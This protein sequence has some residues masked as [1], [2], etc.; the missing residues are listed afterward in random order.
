MIGKCKAIA[1]GSTAL[2]YIFRE[3]KLGCRLAFHNLCSRESKAIHEEMK[4]VSDYN[5]RCRNKFLRIEIGIAPQDEKKLSVSELAQIAHLFAKKMGLDNHQWVA[6]THK[7]TDNRHIHIIANRI[8]LY[9]EVYDTTFVSN[10]AARITEEISREKGLTIAKEVKTE[11]KHQK[12]KANPTREETKK[13]LQKICYIL[14]DKYKCTGI[15]GH[16]MFLYELNKNGITIERVKNK[17]GKVYGLKFS[18]GEHTFKASEIGREF[19]Y[20]S[21]QKNFEAFN[22]EE[23]NKPHQVTQE[24]TEKNERPDTGYQLVPPSRSS[25][26]RDNDTPQVQNPISTVADTIVSAADEVME[27]LGG[28]ITP[29]VQGD[30]YA[31]AAWQRKLR[32]QANRKKRGRRL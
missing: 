20:R 26:S 5:T 3:G 4:V 1:H 27:G 19:G 15:T 17:Q 13:E 21:L 2:D 31:E 9:G 11:R 28:M 7:D 29:T 18:Y 25:I 14:L 8:S 12:A 16:S 10:K 6:V 22:K 24:P 30:D 32:Y 23:S